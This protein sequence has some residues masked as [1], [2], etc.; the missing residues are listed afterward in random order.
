MFENVGFLLLAYLEF[1]K[2]IGMACVFKDCH[3]SLSQRERET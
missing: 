2:I 3:K 1:S